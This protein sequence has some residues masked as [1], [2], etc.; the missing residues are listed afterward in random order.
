MVAC[1]VNFRVFPSR[2][3]SVVSPHLAKLFPRS[4]RAPMEKCRL[5]VLLVSREWRKLPTGRPFRSVNT[6]KRFSFFL[7]LSLSLFLFLSL[8]WSAKREFAFHLQFFS[9]HFSPFVFLLDR[10]P[11]TNESRRFKTSILPSASLFTFLLSRCAWPICCQLSERREEKSF[12]RK[13]NNRVRIQ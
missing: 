9:I 1:R 13:A 7:S 4:R 8:S 11:S 6:L 12:S 3:T 5:A 10:V 2:Q